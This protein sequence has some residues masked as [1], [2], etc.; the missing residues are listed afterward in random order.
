MSETEEKDELMGHQLRRSEDATLNL[1]LN[2]LIQFNKT[3]GGLEQKVSTELDS[4]NSKLDNVTNNLS[5][6]IH[7]E[8]TYIKSLKDEVTGLKQA[9]S[10]DIE[11]LKRQHK[12]IIPFV[13]QSKERAIVWNW[14]IETLPKLSKVVST[15]VF[16]GVA[17]WA[18][19]EF[20]IRYKMF[21]PK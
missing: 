17:A 3:L 13:T 5:T 10:R 8:E 18:F 12:E 21:I 11:T 9:V 15:I 14:A 4:L 19:V 20:I 6:H 2:N 7:E 1:V 16:L